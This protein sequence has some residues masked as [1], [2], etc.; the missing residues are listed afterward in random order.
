MAMRVA[1]TPVLTGRRSIPVRVPVAPRP[2]PVGFP[3]ITIADTLVHL[4]DAA[5]AREAIADAARSRT[6]SPLAVASV[7]LDH[8][9]HLPSLHG[10]APVASATRWMNLID[11]APIA[12]QALRMTGTPWPRLAGSDLITGILTDAQASGSRVA[13]LGG[14]DEIR[15]ALTRR[16]TTDWPTMTFVGHWTPTRDALSSRESSLALAA[17]IRAAGVDIIIVCLGKP[18]QE[19]WINDYAEATG[20][21][22]LLAFGAVVDFLAGRVSRAPHWVSAAGFEWMWRLVLE[23]RRLARRYLIEGPPAYLAVRRSSRPGRA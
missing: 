13:V 12:R 16:F 14:S 15:G 2:T 17:E 22:V 11:G 10:D 19:K 4:T 1:T 3:A 9:H 6:S 8:I 18:R 20:A 21:G 23:P 5:G 7:N